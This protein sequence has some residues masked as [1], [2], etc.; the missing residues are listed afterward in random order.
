MKT[1]NLIDA[2]GLIDEKYIADA[3]KPYVKI[4]HRGVKRLAVAAAA[5][6]CIAVPLPAMTAFGSETAYNLLYMAMPSVAQAFK[7]VQKSCEDKNIRMEVISADIQG[8][9]ASFY[10]SIQGDMIDE[11]IDLYD[12]YNIKC[13]FDSVG[14]VSY[15]DF[16]E[17]TKTAYFVVNIKTMNGEKIPKGKVTFSVRELIFDKH[18][19]EGAIDGIDFSEVSKN[20]PTI[21]NINFRGASGAYESIIVR[22]SSGAYESIIDVLAPSSPLTEIMD[23][24]SVTGIGYI[25]DKLHIQTYYED[26]LKTDNHG[27]VYL[28]DENGKRISEDFADI[29]FW[30]DERKGS[31]DEK[32]FDIDYSDLE[33]YSLMGW[34]CNSNGY[35]TGDWEVTFK[36]K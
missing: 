15:S 18:E 9:E 25:D 3:H 35:E 22:D 33:N 20:P 27:Y 36:M 32:V 14:H 26:I 28:V 7:P 29:S 4:K 34:F 21:E 19:F 11:T 1:E 30:D 12:S 16:D 17:N 10:I 13:P 2:V 31:Y 8:D 23:G 6:L 5:L 24:I